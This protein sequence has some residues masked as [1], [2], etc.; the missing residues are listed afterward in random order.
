[1]EGGISAALVGDGVQTGGLL[2][3]KDGKLDE[4]FLA[5][6]EEYT[7]RLE[8]QHN[9][10]INQKIAA[11]EKIP[12][13]QRQFIAPTDN[14]I[15]IEY[16]V[17]SMADDMMEMAETGELGKQAQEIV[18]KGVRGALTDKAFSMISKSEKQRRQDSLKALKKLLMREEK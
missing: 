18:N 12:A 3:G 5:F 7:Q 9:R 4:N 8:A 13:K 16:F 1:M 14:D 10:Q 15:A 2:R 11:G 6:K 17:D